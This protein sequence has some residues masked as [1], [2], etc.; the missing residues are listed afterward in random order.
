MAAGD[1][2][3]YVLNY[4]YH[5][6]KLANVLHYEQIDGGGDD[7]SQGIIDMIN[8]S[9]FNAVSAFL[10]TEVE[11]D[12]ATMQRVYPVP[13]GNAVSQGVVVSNGG[14]A[15]SQAGHVCA[16]IRKRS[17]YAGRKYRGRIYVPGVPTGCL[18]NGLIS[19]SCLT[20]L[21]AIASVLKTSYTSGSGNY[22]VRPCIYYRSKD[23]LVKRV[24]Y[25]TST[26]V[27]PVPRSQR[28]REIGVGN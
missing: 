5:N 22:T 26:Y 17:N 16:L 27:D 1:V 2:Y 19:G 3:R 23:G 11:M 21:E 15:T 9:W 6:Q 12:E 13:P 4:T 20:K 8:P 10:P 24:V 7:N 25:I 14:G 28:R 18:T